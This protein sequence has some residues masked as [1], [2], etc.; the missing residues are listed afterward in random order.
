MASYLWFDREFDFA[1]PVW[2]YPNVVE[3]LRGTPARLEEL[4]RP[5]T[6]DVLT[7]RDGKRWSIQEHAG[8]LWDVESLWEGRLDDFEA[9]HDALRPADLENTRTYEADHNSR[10]LKAILE[11]FRVARQRLV[12]RL[13]RYDDTFIARSALHPRLKQPMR[14]LDSSFFAAEHDDH[15][16][17]RI[18]E[19]IRKLGK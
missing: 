13:D 11:G 8:H 3:R 4:V 6:S 17:A 9:G 1:I 15:H 19:L 14:V 10:D 7:T 2:M 12:G 18:S 16:L 5:L